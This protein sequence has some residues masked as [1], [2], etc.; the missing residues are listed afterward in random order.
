MSEENQNKKS[1]IFVRI[2]TVILGILIISLII[3][4]FFFFEPKGII[5]NGIIILLGLLMILFLSE[6]FD[7]FSLGQF[8]SLNRTLK[9]KKEKIADLKESNDRLLNLIISNNNLSQHSS[10]TH[11]TGISPEEFAKTIISVIK[12]DKET[13]DKEETRKEKIAEIIIEEEEE[14][15]GGNKKGHTRVPKRRVSLSKLREISLAKFIDN[16]DLKRYNFF[17]DAQILLAQKDIDPISTF[18]P[19]FD[20]YVESENFEMFIEIRPRNAPLIIFRERL[21]VML[22]KLYYYRINKKTNVYLNLI[23]VELP[24]DKSEE[25]QDRKRRYSNYE[26]KLLQEFEPAIRMGLLKIEYLQLSENEISE[27]L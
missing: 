25:N 3:S 27:L 1:N 8:L 16:K 26:T 22:S 4:R 12:A 13:A 24:E 21:Y 20:G 9:E 7:S 14:E 6:I 18:N 19:V 11:V 17:E 15:Q 23:L 10:M 2:L 5:S